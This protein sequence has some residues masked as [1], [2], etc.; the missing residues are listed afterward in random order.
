MRAPL[1]CI[2]LFLTAC[3]Y[4]FEADEPVASVRTITVPYVRGDAEGKLTSELIHQL[5]SSGYFE[6]RQGGGDLLLNAVIVSSN[7]DQIGYRHERHGPTGHLRHRLIGTENRREVVVEISLI[8][9]R[10]NT[11]LIE[12]TKVVAHAEYDYIDPDSIRE[13]LFI[14]NE[15]V[16][17]R[18]ITFS[19]GQLDSVE[20]GQDDSATP[21]YRHLSQKIVDGL[22]NLNI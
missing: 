5:T 8:D 22:I 14:N 21:L 3:G 12:P 13:L 20:G 16:P 11:I 18:T 17:E 2:L 1:L 6:C 7:L 19:L 10:T 15:G 9:T 4:R